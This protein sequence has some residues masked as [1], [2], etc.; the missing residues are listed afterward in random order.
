M[1][2]HGQVAKIG[3]GTAELQFSEGHTF[4]R[5]FYEYSDKRKVPEIEKFDFINYD[6]SKNIWKMD[7][8]R[9]ENTIGVDGL[10]ISAPYPELNYGSHEWRWGD[11]DAGKRHY[12]YNSL[13]HGYERR[14]STEEIDKDI[15]QI[16]EVRRLMFTLAKQKSTGK[17][18]NIMLM[19]GTIFE[20]SHFYGGKDANT[21]TALVTNSR[22]HVRTLWPGDMASPPANTQTGELAQAEFCAADWGKDSTKRFCGVSAMGGVQ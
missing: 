7:G 6:E 13:F 15:K 21:F 20:L 1:F 10:E 17:A 16:I 5:P 8:W 4:P 11:V 9:M 3:I 19:P 14:T 18:E 22:L 12:N 2:V